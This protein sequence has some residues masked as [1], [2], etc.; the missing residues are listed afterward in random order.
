MDDA[1]L[2]RL[3]R[4]GRTC[5][6]NF[7]EDD[8]AQG[9]DIEISKGGRQLGHHAADGD[10]W[11]MMDRMMEQFMGRRVGLFRDFPMTLE[12]PFGGKMPQV[13]VIDGDNEIRV[14]AALPGVDRKDLQVDV[15]QDMVS[16]RGSTRTESKEE[17][18][19]YFRSELM[20]GEFARTIPLPATVD[21]EKARA[22]FRDG[23]LE[24][25][26]PKTEK[27]QRRSIAIE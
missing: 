3:L 8:M 26:L 14:R 25:V 9:S 20:R 27:R 13:D 23:L 7:L 24:L 11:E 12:S 17:R 21:S 16:I 4:A 15:T 22:S 2:Q 19:N 5:H 6:D 18:E 1:A 10:L